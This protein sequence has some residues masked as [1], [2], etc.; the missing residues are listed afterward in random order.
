MALHGPPASLSRP[1]PLQ[2]P[3]RPRGLQQ[4]SP[5]H[6]AAIEPPA[7]GTTSSPFAPPR[8]PVDLLEE[9][10]LAAEKSIVAVG[11]SRGDPRAPF[12]EG[13]SPVPLLP[14]IASAAA[15]DLVGIESR[16]RSGGA[17]PCTYVLRT[18]D[19]SGE[20]CGGPHATLRCFGRQT[21]AWRT[22]F[23]DFSEI[24]RWGDLLKSGVA[25]FDL[26]YDAI[27]AA[28][29]AVSISAEGDC[30]LCLP[31][32]PGIEATALGASESAA[33]GAGESAAP[34]TDES[35]LSVLPCPAVPSGSLS[36]L[37]LPSFS[38]NL[39]SG[40]DL[41]DAWVDQF[42]PGGQRATHCSCASTGRHLA[43]FTHQPGSSLYTLSTVSPPVA[44]SSQVA[45]SGHVFAAASRDLK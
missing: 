12:F 9:R 8:S 28:M 22:Q 45:V 26:D 36:G 30:Y 19:R 14:S 17:G 1:L 11:A 7:A 43:T 18:G 25:I 20:T 29:Y 33:L 3:P 31:P 13:C 24:P 2:Q 39:V 4:P 21:D 38:T 34:G 37:H 41:Q 44:E 27:L 32:D 10:L 16:G 42:T 35:A 40:A 5:A 15:V 23:P 6:A